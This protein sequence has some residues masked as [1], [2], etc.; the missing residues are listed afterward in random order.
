MKINPRKTAIYAYSS[1][2]SPVCLELLISLMVGMI[3]EDS[4]PAVELYTFDNGQTY[5]I[6]YP[7][8]EKIPFAEGGRHR[9]L[10]AYFLGKEMESDVVELIEVADFRMEIIPELKISLDQISI[11]K[12]PETFVFETV[13]MK[14]YYRELPN[15]DEFFDCY[16]KINYALKY[17]TNRDYSFN[18]KSYQ[19]LYN[20]VLEL[21]DK[22]L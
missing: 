2:K 10:A 8:K 12:N 21:Q 11:T 14:K 15:V 22:K 16:N 3:K 7:G 6:P 9:A 5:E 18:R 13:N 19:H 1:D 17:G 4:I 20:A